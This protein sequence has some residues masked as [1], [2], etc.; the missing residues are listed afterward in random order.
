MS[1]TVKRV[2]LVTWRIKA[3]RL[4]LVRLGIAVIDVKCPRLFTCSISCR[5]ADLSFFMVCPLKY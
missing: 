3:G 2:R 5:S 1:S 4:N